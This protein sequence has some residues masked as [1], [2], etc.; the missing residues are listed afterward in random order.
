MS[1]SYNGLRAAAARGLLTGA[2]DIALGGGQGFVA[3]HVLELVDVHAGVGQI[4]GEGLPQA[5]DRGAALA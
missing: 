5:M 2:V 1:L 4:G 3:E